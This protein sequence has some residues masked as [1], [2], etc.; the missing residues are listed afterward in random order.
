MRQPLTSIYIGGAISLEGF[1]A[2]RNSFLFTL[3]CLRSCIL[4]RCNC[5]YV[6][7]SKTTVPG[8]SDHFER[9][10]TQS[11]KKHIYQIM[12]LFMRLAKRLTTYLNSS[13]ENLYF[14]L[15]LSDL[16]KWCLRPFFL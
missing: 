1:Q 11:S 6:I 4:L 8:G 15:L 13:L 3:T 7:L 9:G 12:S 2:V 16:L 14:F 10:I 5:M